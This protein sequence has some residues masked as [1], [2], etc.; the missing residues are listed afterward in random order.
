MAS[1]VS[2][3]AEDAFPSVIR[4][5][6]PRLRAD[7]AAGTSWNDAMID[8]LFVLCQRVEDTTV[9]NRAGPEGLAYVRAKPRRRSRSAA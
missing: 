3:R 6:L 1:G 8:A 7:L 9:L 5:A 2:G 4:H